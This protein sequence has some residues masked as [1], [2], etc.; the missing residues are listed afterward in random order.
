[1]K[2]K[3]ITKLAA[4]SKRQII[5]HRGKRAGRYQKGQ[6]FTKEGQG[7]VNRSMGLRHSSLL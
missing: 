6:G 4:N 2:V 7:S 3:Y 5:K 1:M